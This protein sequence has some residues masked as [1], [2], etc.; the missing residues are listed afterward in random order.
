M[1]T[2]WKLIHN[3]AH[4]TAAQK[5]LKPG[6]QCF[7]EALHPSKNM[8]WLKSPAEINEN[9]VNMAIYSELFNGAE[10]SHLVG[11]E[12]EES[13]FR[14]WEHGMDLCQIA[15]GHK[16]ICQMEGERAFFSFFS[17]VVVFFFFFT[18][19][20]LFQSASNNWPLPHPGFAGRSVKMPRTLVWTGVCKS[21]SS[22]FQQLH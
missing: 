12:R 6:D 16:S 4:Q 10:Q 14:V 5:S 18:E 3:P 19:T 13:V 11:L 8:A 9:W 15:P 1:P 20:Y 22:G 17:V 2:A 21:C 7:W